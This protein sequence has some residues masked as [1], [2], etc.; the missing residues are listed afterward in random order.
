MKIVRPSEFFRPFTRRF[1]VVCFA[2]ALACDAEAAPAPLQLPAFPTPAFVQQGGVPLEISPVRLLRE[3]MRGGVR[4]GDQFETSDR[5]YG[6]LRQD[7]VGVF[8]AWLE[9]ACEGLEI[10]LPRMRR[11]AYDGGAFSRL[12][13]VSVSLGALQNKEAG[14]LAVPIGLL[15]CKR[16]APW[17]ELKRD[18]ALDAYIIFATD[19]G[20]LVYDPP[21]RQLVNLTDFP[22]KSGIV[23]VRF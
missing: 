1:T 22:N 17:G 10:D 20:I 18:G 15:V 13:G 8:A 23:R 16:D 19:A 3:L 21:T 9:K 4:I 5:D 11:L 14:T 12:L 7:N 2:V 6:L